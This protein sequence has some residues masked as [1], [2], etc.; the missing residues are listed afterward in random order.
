M[1]LVAALATTGVIL[2]RRNRLFFFGYALFFIGLLPVSQIVPLVTLM[3]DRY[4]YFPLL[5]VAWLAGGLTCRL[6]DVCDVRQRRLAVIS[7]GVLMAGF[8]LVSYQRT[9]VWKNSVSLWSD[10]VRK[11]PDSWEVR[12]ALAE[13]QV[14]AGMRAEALQTYSNVFGLRSD[15]VDPILERK[16]LN[17]AASLYMDNGKFDIARPLLQ[18]LVERFP[19]YP[20]G[21]I[22]LGYNHLMTHNLAAAEQAYRTV[23]ALQPGNTLA[24]TMLG[25]I[26]L[27]AGRADSARE[28]YHQA[29]SYGG[30][31]PELQF[32]LACLEAYAKHGAVALQHLREALQL[33]YRDY[34]AITQNPALAP[35]RQLAEYRELLRSYFPNTP[36]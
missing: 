5:G 11:L 28:L 26:S 17:N 33:G 15:S 21:F 3:N 2:Q 16:A 19:D 4:L 1:L 24:L 34:N 36:R 20:L 31:G 9:A 10:A 18:R 29:L 6:I 23:L 27:D 12:A 35:V 25:N 14:N 7:C 8:A 22:N 30:N 13:A 32:N